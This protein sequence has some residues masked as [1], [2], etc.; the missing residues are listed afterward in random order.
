MK[1]LTILK[2]ALWVSTS[3][4]AIGFCTTAQAQTNNDE[5]T[6]SV[7]AEDNII[8]TA[9]RRE[10]RIQDVPLS[11]TAYQPR[12]LVEKGITGYEELA[13]ETP[14][15]ILNKPT[16]NFNNFTARGI[17]TNGYGAGLQA[18]VTIYI[19]EL[20]ISANGNSTILDPNLFDVERIE[21]LRGPQGTLFGSGSLA[22][23]MRIITNKPDLSEFD[24]SAL[25]DFGL[26][27][28]DAFRQRYNG[29]VNIPIVEDKAALRVVGFYRNEEG[30]VDNIG[31]G[32]ENSNSLEAWGGRASL[33]IE[34]TQNLSIKLLASHEESSPRDSGLTN[35]DLGTLVRNSDR[36][37]LFIGNLDTL[38]ATI[39]YDFENAR[40]TSSTTLTS[41]DGVFFVDLA[42][43]FSQ[44]I[45][46]ALDAIGYD[47]IFVQ[48]LRLASTTNEKLDWIVGGFY[49]RKRRDVDF[50][51]RSSPEFL[52]AR[53]ITGLSD[54]YYQRR[55]DHSITHELAGFGELT[56]HVNDKMWLTGGLRYGSTDAQGFADGGFTSNY[57]VNALYGIPGPLTVTDIAAGEGI[58]AEDTGLSYKAS[59]SYKPNQELTTYATVST[60][61]RQPIRN[62]LAGLA[63]TLDPNDIIIPDGADSDKLTN[64]ELGLKGSWLDGKLSANLA[65]Y[66]IDWS[67]IQVQAN[68][69]S[70]SIQFA[71]NI[72]KAVSKGFEFEV[73]TKPFDGFFL[74]F[75]GAFVDAKV[76]ELTASE[77]A[78][79]GAVKG[80]RLAAPKFQGSIYAKYSFNWNANTTGWVAAN[81]QHI[82]SFPSMFPNV[83]GSPGTVQATYGLTDSYE[84]VNM[85]VGADFGDWTVTGYVEN[86]LDDDSITYIHPEAFLDGRFGVMRPRTFGIRFAY[87]IK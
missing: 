39:N 13:R 40:L 57:F 20:P 82:G 83:P 15:V 70:D 7:A 29:M 41:Y 21:F 12:E 52:L 59:V 43:T 56:Y 76:T 62:S 49:F 48:E 46:F 42:G 33:L 55:K 60:G 22:G 3:M 67:S 78:F 19:D 1:N 66:Y 26:T 24:Y 38:N 75:N 28:G 47:D 8:V 54:E 68:R 9:T 77:A 17:A 65:A 18:T 35:P 71:T 44:A 58:I 86:L 34:P 72:G 61:F 45:P 69:V 37:D 31:T 5:Q 64:Y 27:G 81:I 84:N 6:N 74:G 51:Y 16:A 32:I 79:S 80:A 2:Q 14:G 87:G 25:V 11:I 63:S 10:Q 30:F 85:S 23:A 73:G 4:L 50:N 36:P 53:G